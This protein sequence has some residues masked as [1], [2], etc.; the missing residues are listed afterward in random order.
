MITN[1]YVAVYALAEWA[2]TLTIFHLYQYII[3][4]PVL[5]GSNDKKSPTRLSLYLLTP[6]PQQRPGCDL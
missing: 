6:H 1:F 3:Y 2:D 4:V 5:Y